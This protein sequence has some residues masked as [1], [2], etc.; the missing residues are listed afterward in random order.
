M[1]RNGILAL[2]AATALFA[3]EVR[4]VWIARDSLGSRERVRETMQ[5]IANAN[6]NTAYVLVWS[7]GYPLHKSAVFER[8]TGL[9]NDPQYGDRD[10]LQEAIDEAKPL[11]IT[12]IPWLEYGFVG[13]WSG[14][15]RGD[16]LGPIFDKHPDWLAKN[17]AGTSRFAIP[18]NAYYHWMIHTHPDAQNFL[19]EMMEELIANYDVPGVQFDR[20]RYPDLDCGYDD[21]TKALYAA[22]HDGAPP[23]D[24]PRDAEWIR[25]RADKLNQFLVRAN[26]RLKAVNWRTLFTNAPVPTPD[27]Y[28]SFAQDPPG[29]VKDG[30]HDFLSPQIY[31]R[32][33]VTFKSK[34]ELHM[35]MYGDSS[36][37]VP[38]IAVDTTNP[39]RIVQII[40]SV[41]SAGLP[42]V[43]IW[44][45]EDL[46]KSKAYDLL[47]ATVF[48]EKAPLPWK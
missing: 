38:G 9:R 8:E 7:Q 26:K 15:L 2:L 1:V 27:G 13:V 11:G 48:A 10:I 42:G 21:H 47:K 20:A 14:R 43:V 4:G 34:L 18:G 45:H 23:P 32:D 37:L 40:E 33:L 12:V 46:Q 41:R 29:W 3:G 44:Y 6:L 19:I 36:R 5:T 25:W 31:W 28:G 16:S 17:R 39:E 35:R 22:E 30:S 24:N